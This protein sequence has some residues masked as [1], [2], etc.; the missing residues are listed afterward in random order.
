MQKEWRH[1]CWDFLGF[2]PVNDD[3]KVFIGQRIVVKRLF[4]QVVGP[5]LPYVEEDQL[6]KYKGCYILVLLG[7]TIFM[8]KSDDRMHLI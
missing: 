5:L 3:T 8:D 1:V 4:E 7:D 2:E 6:H